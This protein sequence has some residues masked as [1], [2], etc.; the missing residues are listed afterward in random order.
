[1]SIYSTLPGNSYGYLSGTSMA[2][3]Q[4]SGVAALAWALNPN[5]T[6]AQVRSAILAGVDQVPALAGKVA[7]GGRLDAYNT[8]RLIAR[9]RPRPLPT[10]T[11]T[12]AIT[13]LTANP[14]A[15]ATGGT[16][17]LAGTRGF[18]DGRHDRRGLFLS[19]HQRQR[20]VG[21]AATG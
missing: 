8:L 1:M 12:P 19:R 14:S 18:R 17:A 5:A 20:P 13:S 3:P 9:P 4:V 2:T 15:I 21:R 7:S 10:P 16:V 6:V 11:P